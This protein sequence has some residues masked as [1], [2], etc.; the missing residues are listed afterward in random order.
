MEYTFSHG[1][2]SDQ[3]PWAGFCTFPAPYAKREELILSSVGRWPDV[4]LSSPK[5]TKEPAEGNYNSAFSHQANKR[6][7]GQKRI[8]PVAD[9]HTD[10][11][12]PTND[13]TTRGSTQMYGNH[14]HYF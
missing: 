3:S 1:N 10:S 11:H 6:S 8:N 9:S 7:A 14:A 2:R 5:E 13:S 12:P 4:T